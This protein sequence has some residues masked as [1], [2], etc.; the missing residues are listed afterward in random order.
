MNATYTTVKRSSRGG[1]TNIQYI[2]CQDLNGVS[3]PYLPDILNALVPC[4]EH[5]QLK[6]YQALQTTEKYSLDG[7]KSTSCRVYRRTNND[8]LSEAKTEIGI[9]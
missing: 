7:V 4:A 9:L 6:R 8:L 1:C 2:H 3:C 5:K